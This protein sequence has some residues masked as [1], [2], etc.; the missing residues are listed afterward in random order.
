MKKTIWMFAG[1]G[2]QFYQMGRELFEKERVFRDFFT[3]ASERLEKWINLS[4]VDLVYRPRPSRFEPFDRTLYSHPA[5]FVFECA[6][7]ETLL[8]RGCRPDLL[9]GYSLGEFAAYVIAGCIPFEA[10]L[11]AVVKMAELLEYCAPA[12]GMVAVLESDDLMRRHPE[13]FG[14]CE[15]AGRNFERGFV[16][17]GLSGPLARTKA[18]LKEKGIQWL[19]PPGVPPLSPPSTRRP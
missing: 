9:L 10:A 4:L 5:I 7:A 1:Q 6:L 2:A 14:E 11:G 3:R 19:H 15:M 12:G 17:S 18:F 13:G 16:V 8:Q